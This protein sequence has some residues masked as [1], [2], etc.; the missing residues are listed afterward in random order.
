MKNNDVVVGPAVTS[1]HRA[2][3]GRTHGR[4]MS[5][6]A[7]CCDPMSLHVEVLLDTIVTD[8]TE[9]GVMIGDIP[10]ASRNVIWAAGNTASPLLKLL[11]TETDRQ[12]RVVVDETCAIPG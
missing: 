1:A 2:Y 5:P 6:V 9:D 4:E 7:N 12:G 10:I 3:V 8:V 11:G